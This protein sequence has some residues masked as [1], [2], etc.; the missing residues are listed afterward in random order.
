MYRMTSYSVFDFAVLTLWLY[1]VAEIKKRQRYVT[2]SVTE[3]SA[4]RG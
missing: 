1:I 4:D 2:K 3:R